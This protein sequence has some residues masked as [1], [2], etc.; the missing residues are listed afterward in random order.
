MRFLANRRA[1]CRA[2]QH[3]ATDATLV[4]VAAVIVMHP[5]D[6]LALRGISAGA[7]DTMATLALAD[8]IE[9]AITFDMTAMAGQ[10][11][12]MTVLTTDR[13]A[14]HDDIL[15]R[16]ESGADVDRPRRVVTLAT[17]LL[18]QGEDTI[19][20]RPGVGKQRIAGRHSANPMTEVTR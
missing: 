15:Y 5:G 19:S 10:T 11:I 8:P 20:T 2:D 1:G 12:V 16:C 6:D 13:G 4:T 14:A 7:A 18:V 17:T 3:A 9:A